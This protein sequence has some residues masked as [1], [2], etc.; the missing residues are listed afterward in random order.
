MSVVNNAPKPKQLGQIPFI[1]ALAIILMAGMVGVL[2]L[3]ITIQ[4]G[5]VELR[6]IQAQAVTLGNQ[7][8]ALQAESDRLGSVTSLEQQAAALGMCPNPNAAFVNLQTGQLT[9]RV[10]PVT[11][12]ELPNTIPTGR[13]AVPPPFDIKIYPAPNSPQPNQVNAPEGP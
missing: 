5:S 9:G 7:A 3:S 2:V 13:T 12:T 10:K 11:C 6:N 4:S 8:D 1:V